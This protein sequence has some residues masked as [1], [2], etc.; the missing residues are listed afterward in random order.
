MKGRE[1]VD[2]KN[3]VVMMSLVAFEVPQELILGLIG[4]G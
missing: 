2:M 3:L 1:V 4:G